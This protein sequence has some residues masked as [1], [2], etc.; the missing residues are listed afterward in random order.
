MLFILSDILRYY[1]LLKLQPFQI[2]FTSRKEN[3]IQ[4]IISEY[5]FQ[6]E[7]LYLRFVA[8]REINDLVDDSIAAVCRNKSYMDR[9]H[10]NMRTPTDCDLVETVLCKSHIGIFY[11]YVVSN[12]AD[13]IAIDRKH[14]SVTFVQSEPRSFA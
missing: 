4:V 5:R 3:Q 10:L 13:G 12:L 7:S 1:L 8:V 9:I 2:E 11:R 14:I 6:F